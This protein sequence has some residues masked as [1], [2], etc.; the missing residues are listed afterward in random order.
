LLAPPSTGHSSRAHRHGGHA[1]GGRIEAPM[2]GKITVV[3]ARAGDRVTSRQPL[4]IMEA[5]KM[6][7]SIVAPYEGTVIALPARAGD[8]VTA[9]DLLAEIEADT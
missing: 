1:A 3:S 9:G 4:V 2:S 6:E 7:H 5:M 8:S